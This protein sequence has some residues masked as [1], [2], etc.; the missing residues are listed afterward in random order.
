MFDRIA[1]ST[2]EVLA[3]TIGRADEIGLEVE[4]LPPWYDVDEGAT[5]NQLCEELFL[6][7]RRDGNY[8]APHTRAY[9]ATLIESRR[10]FPELAARTTI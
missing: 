3:H 10:V 8:P 4:L 9:L 1:W 2:G 7:R 5:L 6:S